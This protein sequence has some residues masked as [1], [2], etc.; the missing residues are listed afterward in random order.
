M[1]VIIYARGMYLEHVVFGAVPGELLFLASA[2]VAFK[3]AHWRGSRVL[4][5]K[6]L[7]V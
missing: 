3:I 2:G 7:F 6:G 5:H 1:V 4:V